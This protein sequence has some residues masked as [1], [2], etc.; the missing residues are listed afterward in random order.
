ME[1][2]PI[3]GAP[4]VTLTLYAAPSPTASV[5][6]HAPTAVLTVWLLPVKVA[7][8]AAIGGATTDK[9]PALS[10]PV[11]VV[12]SA[13]ATIGAAANALATNNPAMIREPR[14]LGKCLIRYLSARKPL[15]TVLT[16]ATRRRLPLVARLT[17]AE[18][19]GFANPPRDGSALCSRPTQ[20]ITY[21]QR[22]SKT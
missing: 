2:P 19:R 22:L 6:L 17:P 11:A 18:S 9:P 1:V 20:S 3:V 10:V 14:G 16:C 8:N 4:A 21:R 5:R 15:L 12:V 7:V 13:C